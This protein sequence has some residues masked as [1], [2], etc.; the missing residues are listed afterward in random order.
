MSAIH[1]ANRVTRIK[2]S[3]SST[4]SDRA[5][6]L[7]RAG[8]SIVNLV[9]GEPD[10]DTPAVIR[11]AASAAIERGE[12]RY[13]QNNGTPALRA[14]IAEKFLRE[15][16]LTVNADDV[17]VTNGAKSAIFNAFAATLET[18]DEVLIPA[19]FWVSYPDMVL[20]AMAAR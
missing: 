11:Q 20:A 1:I 13:T 6:A 14:A 8:K 16:R 15:N 17:I 2:P 9:V 5:N 12:T 4:A 3:P 19:P 10:F 7:K 18:G